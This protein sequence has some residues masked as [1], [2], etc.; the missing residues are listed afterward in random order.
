ML[1]GASGFVGSH[2]AEALIRMGLKPRLFVR[3]K[4]PLIT[5]LE[6][7]GAEIFI[8]TGPG[9]RSVIHTFRR[10]CD[11]S[12]RCGDTSQPPGGF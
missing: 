5:S 12:L 8:G 11:Y 9:D 2:I 7:Q 6:D 1:T 10:G 4:P 3:E